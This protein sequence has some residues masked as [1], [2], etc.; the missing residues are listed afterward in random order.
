MLTHHP[1]T[2]ADK[3][4]ICAWVYPGDYALYNLPSYEEMCAGQRGF[5]HPER[6]ANFHGFSQGD[7][8]VGFVNLLEEE[9]EVF[10]GIGVSPALCGRGYGQRMLSQTRELAASLYPGKPLY[11]EVRTWN[12]RAIRC[13]E[14]AGFRMDGEAFERVTGS[15]KGTFYR[16]IRE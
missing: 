11:L 6:A 16:M 13:Y 9:R 15:G 8:L 5:C 7:A 1:L 10:V 4:A 3:R 2:E 14:K 12:A